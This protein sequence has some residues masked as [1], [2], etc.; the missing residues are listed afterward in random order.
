M[1]ELSNA[2]QAV[3][4]RHPEACAAADAMMDAAI[5]HQRIFDLQ[6]SLT[7]WRSMATR[8]GN[9]I[10]KS[11][12]DLSREEAAVLVELKDLQDKPL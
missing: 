11:P 10:A 6:C 8:L 4:D 2:I 12:F 9:V 3:M 5:L 1:S 7:Q